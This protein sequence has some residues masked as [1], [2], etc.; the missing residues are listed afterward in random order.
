MASMSLTHETTVELRQL[1]DGATFNKESDLP[2]ASVVVTSQSRGEL[3]HHTSRSSAAIDI[4]SKNSN[5]AGQEDDILWLA[6]CTKLVTSI[7][8]MQLVEQ[9]KLALDDSDQVEGL[10]PELK[11]VQVV[12]EDGSLVPKQRPITLRMLLTHTGK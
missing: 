2:Y 8:C 9:G 4:A 12:Q 7:A 11:A 3:F 1:V 5:D 10:C 6:S